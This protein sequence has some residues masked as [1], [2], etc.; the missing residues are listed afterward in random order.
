MD[1][2]FANDLHWLSSESLVSPLVEAGFDK[3]TIIVTGDPLFDKQFKKINDSK[4][5]KNKNKINVL[6]APSTFYEHGLCTKSEQDNAIKSVLEMI[7]KNNSLNLTLKIHPSSANFLDYRNLVDSID[8]SIQIHQSGN[9]SDYIDNSDLLIVF[10]T[11]TVC[12][13][14]LAAKK[15]IIIYN[16]L[17]MKGD[18]F[19]ENKVVFECKELSQFCSLIDLALNNPISEENINK[20]LTNFYYKT[21]GLASQRVANGIFE[22]LHKNIKK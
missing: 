2:R 17:G 5:K 8:S 4:H 9:I 22:L 16:F 14:A 1:S 19:I 21:D 13:F 20:F 18:V 10:P 7:L 3:N 6:F 11:T 12:V 15:P